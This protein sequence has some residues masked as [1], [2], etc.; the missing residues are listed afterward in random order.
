MEAQNTLS[1][2][3]TRAA[4]LFRWIR[5]LLLL[6]FPT[7]AAGI[8][9]H[10]KMLVRFPGLR[11]PG[12]ALSMLT[13]LAY[14]AILLRLSA[15]KRRYRTAGNCLIV[16]AGATFLTEVL[17][18]Y[19][20]SDWLIFPALLGIILDFCG[21]YHEYFAHSAALDE[22][23]S[24]CARHWRHLWY[25]FVLIYAAMIFSITLLVDH[26]QLGSWLFAGSS[27]A[28]AIVTVTKLVYLLR[29]IRM[30]KQI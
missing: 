28:A 3:K 15:V 11:L 18:V 16:S 1:E 23:D 12:E 4:F 24:D 30:L 27:L 25:W 20:R 29:T 13:Q 21:I 2:R 8:L 22:F 19:R 10:E 26:P 14:G 7:I 6:I 9:T 5:A 17:G